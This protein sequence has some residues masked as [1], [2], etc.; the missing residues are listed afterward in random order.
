MIGGRASAARLLLAVAS[1]VALVGAP[2]PSPAAA[3]TPVLELLPVVTSGLSSPVLVT[4]AGDARLFVVEQAGRI[5]IVQGGA[6]LATP[7]LDI[8]GPVLDGGERGL[9]GLAFHPQ[10]AANGRLFVF[11]TRDDGD[12]QIS[13]FRR[14]AGD[15]NLADPGSERGILRIEHTANTN[16][17]GGM[18]AFGPDGMLYVATGDGGG[19]GDPLGS[20]QDASSRLGK[21]LRIDVDPA[22]P[23]DPYDVPPDNPFVGAAG[24]DLVWSLGL[25][26]PWRFSFDRTTGDLWIGDV[27]QGSWEEIDRATAAAGRGRGVNFGWN[28]AEGSHCYNAASC[29]QAGLTLPLAE[30]A[31]GS[32]DCSVTGGHVYRGSAS[33]ALAG[34]YLFG[35]FCSG[36][37]RS[38]VAGGSASQQPTLLLA[39]AAHISSFGEDAAGEL[40]VVDHGG[41]I[42][43]LAAAG[44]ITRSAGVDR[45][46]TAAATSA[47]SFEP[48]VPVVFVATGDNYPDALAGGPAAAREGGPVLLVRRDSIPPPVATELDRLDPGRIVVLGGTAVVSDA[49]ATALDGYTTGAVT[50]LAGADRYATAAAV[51]GATFRPNVPVAYVATGRNYPDALAGVPAAAAGGGPILLVPGTFIP[52]SVGAELDRLNPV[53]IVV[54]GGSAVVSDG[55]VAVLGAYATGGVTRLAGADR[56]GTAAA[57]S[58]AAFPSPVPVAYVA[59]G[60]NYPD[61]LAGGPAAAR[62]GGPVLLVRRDS[63]PAPVAT[64]LDRLDPGRIVVLGGSAAVSDPV[65]AALAGYVAP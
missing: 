24:D 16:H 31:H 65:A 17:N 49:V 14:S 18:L 32:G 48:G 44:G 30:Y 4:H 11:Y 13:E 50:R 62:E 27:G 58:A 51:S 53:R 6:L 15:A 33:P 61:A 47:A 9:L 2:S 34:L 19:A 5:R 7:F 1:T 36:R 40:Y 35:D 25:R 29:D 64:E 37:I 41:A 10:Y 43:R 26:N 46:A 54:L 56:Y 22:N 52:S 55:V 12:L 38:V 39:T 57:I 42:H 23:S 59:T 20:G 60:Q 8:S 28:V 45:Y 21:I 63:I 3:A